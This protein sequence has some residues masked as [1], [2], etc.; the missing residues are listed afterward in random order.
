MKETPI[1]SDIEEWIFLSSEETAERKKYTIAGS[2]S[3]PLK[4][5]NENNQMNFVSS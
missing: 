4:W 3:L 1:H 2:F 5:S